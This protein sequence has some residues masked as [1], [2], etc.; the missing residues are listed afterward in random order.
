MIYTKLYMQKSPT[1]NFKNTTCDYLFL[2][3][4]VGHKKYMSRNI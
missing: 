2:K 1:R 4:I 3:F